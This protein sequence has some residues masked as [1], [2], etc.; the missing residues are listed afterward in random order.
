M[1]SGMA[2]SNEQQSPGAPL[3]SL[4]SS[5]LAKRKQLSSSF[6]IPTLSSLSPGQ[7]NSNGDGT[8]TSRPIRQF[9]G[10]SSSFVRSW[11]GLPLS[12]VQLRGLAEGNVGKA[13]LFGF[14][15]TGQRVVWCEI[16]QG[17]PKVRLELRFLEGVG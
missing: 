15:T 1:D 4:P 6:S 11:E 16:G 12:A 13:A 8:S 2:S 9:R 10:T 17:R 5:A 3:S 14:Y 7:G